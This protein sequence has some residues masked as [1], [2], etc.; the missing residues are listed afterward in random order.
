MDCGCRWLLHDGCKT[1]VR[2][3]IKESGV[4]DWRGRRRLVISQSGFLAGDIRQ[5]LE[6]QRCVAFLQRQSAFPN[7]LA[8]PAQG[9]ISG[10][11]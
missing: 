7:R 1:A 4:N 9:V 3:R 8:M 5:S 6:R 11:V 10:A 2:E